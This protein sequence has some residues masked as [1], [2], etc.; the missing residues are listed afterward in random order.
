MHIDAAMYTPVVNYHAISKKEIWYYDAGLL[1]ALNM[2]S[3]QAYQNDSLNM[4]T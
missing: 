4:A 3:N 1:K 2:T